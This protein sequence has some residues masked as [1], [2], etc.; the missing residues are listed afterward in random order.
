MVLNMPDIPAPMMTNRT[1][2]HLSA[3][4]RPA[5]SCHDHTI[6]QKQSRL[7]LIG[8][9]RVTSTKNSASRFPMPMFAR[10]F[11]HEGKGFFDMFEQH[12]RKTLEA[13]ELLKAMLVNPTDSA[14]QAR[15]I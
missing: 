1:S 10:L 2:L 11:P 12:A 5:S 4:T 15:R 8:H 7:A 6:G 9:G 3:D 14:V 13:A